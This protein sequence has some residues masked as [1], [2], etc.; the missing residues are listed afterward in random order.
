LAG[1]YEFNMLIRVVKSK[2]LIKINDIEQ[3]IN[4]FDS[5]VKGISQAG[6]EQQEVELY[7]KEDLAFP[8]G[9]PF[10]RSWLDPAYK[11]AE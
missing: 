11:T 3:L 6:E 7:W 5:S 10:P 4:P 1:K 8:S 2:D 9:E